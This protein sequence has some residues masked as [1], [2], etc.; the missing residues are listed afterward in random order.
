MPIYIE[1]VW[2]KQFNK[3]PC[4]LENRSLLLPLFIHI[5]FLLTESYTGSSVLGKNPTVYQRAAC[6]EVVH[7]HTDMYLHTC[8]KSACRIPTRIRQLCAH[9]LFS[10]RTNTLFQWAHLDTS[11]SLTK[12]TG[13]LSGL[14]TF[15]STSESSAS[16]AAL[17][18][19][20]AGSGKALCMQL[21]SMPPVC[22]DTAQNWP[23]H[24]HSTCPQSV[25]SHQI[26]PRW[27]LVSRLASQREPNN[28]ND[29]QWD[30]AVFHFY[31]V[32]ISNTDKHWQK[33]LNACKF[34]D[35]S[36]IFVSCPDSLQFYFDFVFHYLSPE[37]LS[38]K[39]C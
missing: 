37:K 27:Q 5:Y 7:I 39:T 12:A 33:P 29:S 14:Q 28:L 31:L 35:N 17:S 9:C 19:A 18:H 32:I 13:A 20:V 38:V 15:Q 26:L 8:I 22:S 3:I 21:L 11:S 2:L 4:T 23:K 30:Q 36:W 25:H 16:K 6:W 1:N 34:T 10:P 24:T